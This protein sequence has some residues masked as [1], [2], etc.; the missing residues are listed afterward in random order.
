MLDVQTGQHR[1]EF[2]RRAIVFLNGLLIGGMI[3]KLSHVRLLVKDYL[4]CL[5]LYRDVMELEV[6]W[7]DEETNYIS[8]KTGGSQ[9]GLFPRSDMATAVG[10]AHKPVNAEHQPSQC[11]I[12]AVDDVDAIYA[13]LKSKGVRCI[14]TPHDMNN[15]GVRCF[16]LYDPDGNLIEVNKEM[17]V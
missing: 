14:N 12:M 15:W 11:L 3:L 9:I 16:H 2:G 4:S 7:G 5:E 1:S 10:E 6:S 17:A 13:L 8:F